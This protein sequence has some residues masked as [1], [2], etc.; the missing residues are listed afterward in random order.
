MSFYTLFLTAAALFP[1]IALC[2]F[3]YSR[4]RVEKEPV[5][6]LL[7][8]FIF[9]ALSC[10]P[11]IVAEVVLEEVI[12]GAFSHV[13]TVT[14]NTI[15]Y[16]NKYYYYIYLFAQQFFGVALVEEGGK[17]LILLL[18]TMNNRNF[19]SLFDG[20]IYAVF[21]S[22]GFAALENIF[23]VFENGFSVAVLRAVL[24]VPGHAFFAVM[25][26]Y[27]YSMWH[28]KNRAKDIEDS[29]RQQGLIQSR[30]TAF[31]A[32]QSIILSIV[33]PVTIHS[34]YNFSLMVQGIFLILFIPFMAFLYFFCFKPNS[35]LNIKIFISFGWIFF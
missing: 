29:Y 19:N 13:I 12:N 8:L 22:L 28:I 17:W 32:S 26:G 23:Y 34:V 31:D 24:S 35:S 14:E 10:F 4:D 5:G 9:G 27:H 33:I 3:V 21:V 1:A 30:C 6:L 18:F 7:R 25:M 20:L 11:A 16:T 15:S 2:V